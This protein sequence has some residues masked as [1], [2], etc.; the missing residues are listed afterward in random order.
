MKRDASFIFRTILIFLKI[1]NE[2]MLV[3]IDA[4]NKNYEFVFFISI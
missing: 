4:K 3:S 2:K 1:N